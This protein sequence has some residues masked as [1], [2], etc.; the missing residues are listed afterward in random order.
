M[1]KQ[2]EETPATTQRTPFESAEERMAEF[3]ENFVQAA[4]W[5]SMC[6]KLTG[7]R[8]KDDPA[9]VGQLLAVEQFMS[10]AILTIPALNV[11]DA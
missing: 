7:L 6:E 4:M 8:E 11:G 10:Q 2:K 9:S 1:E 3:A 5:S